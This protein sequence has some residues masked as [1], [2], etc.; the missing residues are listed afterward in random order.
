M[1]FFEKR[2]LVMSHDDVYLLTAKQLY[3]R[4][5]NDSKSDLNLI[6]SATELVRICRKTSFPA[7]Y[8]LVIKCAI[9]NYFANI[10]HKANCRGKRYIE[11]DQEAVQECYNSL[12][13]VK[14]QRAVLARQK[15]LAEVINAVSY[16]KYYR[17][18]AIPTPIY[19]IT[20]SS[21][22]YYYQTTVFLKLQ[23]SWRRF[24]FHEYIS[25]EKIDFNQLV[26]KLEVDFDECIKKGKI[27]ETLENT[28]SHDG[29]YLLTTKQPCMNLLTA[30]TPKQLYERVVN[31]S[32]SN[33]NWIT[34]A[35]ELVRICK[36]TSFP[37]EYALVI[38]CA[39]LNCFANIEHRANCGAIPCIK[40][41]QEAV[42]ECYN[43]LY[44]VEDQ[45]AV[46]A[47]QRY[48]TEVINTV[49]YTYYYYR[50]PVFLKLE[51]SWRKSKFQ[52]YISQEKIDFNQLVKKLEADF[53][54]FI[55]KAEIDGTL[56]EDKKG[57]EIML[58]S[59]YEKIKND[60]FNCMKCMKK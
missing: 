7:E 15:Y 18:F 35:T 34:S 25:Q 26:K 43:S 21:H 49:S 3:E 6:T 16:V 8:A 2:Y 38:K 60:I 54:K 11:T 14:D 10:Q 13:E 56:E 59:L 23:D 44:E 47:R 57:E 55:K 27:N 20:R 1:S 12:Y 24:K 40:T 45:R 42:Q 48:L 4:V 31:D 51:D 58:K 41:D 22:I 33:F 46:L 5:V 36:E 9:L 53:D 19:E 28:M 30:I 37:A 29:V 50:G 39:I 32:K 52:E 17:N